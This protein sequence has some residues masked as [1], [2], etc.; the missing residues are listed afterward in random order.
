MLVIEKGVS[1]DTALNQFTITATPQDHNTLNYLPGGEIQRL[2]SLFEFQ[3]S[4]KITADTFVTAGVTPGGTCWPGGERR[5]L[6]RRRRE[7]PEPLLDPVR[8]QGGAASGPAEVAM[9]GDIR[10][11]RVEQVLGPR[12]LLD[13]LHVEIGSSTDYYVGADRPGT[14]S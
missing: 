4:Y 1:L 8:H 12:K 5:G 14:S 13:K 9:H 6:D 3:N 10:A 2:A 11:G 7:Q